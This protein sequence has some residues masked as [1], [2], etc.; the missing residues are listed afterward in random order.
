MDFTVFVFGDSRCGK[1]SFCN[2][3][4]EKIFAA[5]A[6]PHGD[7]WCHWE[8][9][10]DGEKC[11]VQLLDT[12]GQEEVTHV[13]DARGREYEGTVLLYSIASR[14]SFE[15]T[16]LFRDLVLR[17]KDV[18]SFPMVL[19][20]TCADMEEMRA[21]SA[22]EGQEAAQAMQAAFFEVSSKT[23]VNIDEALEQLVRMIRH[24]K[25]QQQQQQV[26]EQ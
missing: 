7:R 21:V 17:V 24:A 2:Q 22:Q 10:V 23:R 15:A 4:C 14:S 11:R 3:L 13:R 16:R 19:V 25:Q 18:D 20:G 12:G 26:Q 9:T 1:S 8:T 6:G 5:D